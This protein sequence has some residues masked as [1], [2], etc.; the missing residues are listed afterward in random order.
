NVTILGY[1]RPGPTMDRDIYRVTRKKG[2]RISVEV[3]SV[4]LSNIW[5]ARGELDLLVRILDATG[6]ELAL[7]DHTPMLVQDP[8][9]SIAAPAD[10]DYFVEI[11]QSL[12][13]DTSNTF[14][15]HYLA[16]I[17]TF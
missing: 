13:S 2:E 12:Y 6:K 5:W 11:G 3:N 15:Q 9:L 14:Y 16:H 7:S 17:G 1:I 10:G 8:L 4:R